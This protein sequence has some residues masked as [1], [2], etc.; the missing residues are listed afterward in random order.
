MASVPAAQNAFPD[1]LDPR[2]ERIF[3]GALKELP[4]HVPLLY[5]MIPSNGRVDMRWSEVGEFTDWEL[6]TGQ[7]SYD[8]YDEGYDVVMTPL[9]F[10]KG[11]QIERRLVDTAQYL[12]M[13]QRPA[14]MGRSFQRT[15]QAYAYGLLN[16]AFTVDTTFYVHSE[17]VP[18]CSNSHTTRSSD[19]STASGFDNLGTASL[20]AT[21]VTAAKIQ[22]WGLR[23]SR[24]ERID[25]TWNELWYPTDLFD[26]AEE[27]IGSAGKPDLAVNNINVHQGKY[28]GYSSV[29]M[30]DTNNW[31]LCDSAMR[32]QNVLWCD[33]KSAEF[34]TVEDFDTLIRK[35]RGYAVFGN[36]RRDWRWVI[37]NQVS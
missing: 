26:V 29:Y 16:N 11:F 30:T 25:T 13:D 14:G 12:E 34:A 36:A 9:E 31:F 24:G 32:R 4:D 6:F 7:V 37:G 10:T 5:T 33:D 8:G 2:F 15:R 35:Y 3:I 21:A 28:T 27:I 23:G 17:G 20:S 22:G 1:V 18:L 19:V